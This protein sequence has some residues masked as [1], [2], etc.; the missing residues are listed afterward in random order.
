MPAAPYS[1]KISTITA[2]LM[3]VVITCYS[4]SGHRDCRSYDD[5]IATVAAISLITAALRSWRSSIATVMAATSGS[6][7]VITPGKVAT[8]AR[9]SQPR[10]LTPD[11]REHAGMPAAARRSATCW[12][13]AAGE[14]R[15]GTL[16]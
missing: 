7:T 1:R 12:Q 3:I 6:I 11:D 2:V 10:P 16:R 5:K 8:A 9:R 4:C 13:A 15:N 14:G